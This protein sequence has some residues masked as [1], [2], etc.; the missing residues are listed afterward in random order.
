MANSLA[1]DAAAA[2]KEATLEVE[3]ADQAYRRGGSGSLDALNAANA[4]L[5]DCHFRLTRSTAAW[6]ATSGGKRHR[7]SAECRRRHL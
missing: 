7:T 1:Q 4:K 2:I 5:A 3:R 6:F